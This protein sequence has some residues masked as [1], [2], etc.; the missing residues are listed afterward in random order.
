[1]S[2][3]NMNMD[4]CT[5][6][7]SKRISVANLI[8]NP[9][10]VNNDKKAEGF[11]IFVGSF[12][13]DQVY[14]RPILNTGKN[15]PL[16]IS[17]MWDD[18]GGNNSAAFDVLF[19]CPYLFRNSKDKIAYLTLHCNLTR[20]EVMKI[21][22]K[23]DEFKMYL[24]ANRLIMYIYDGAE[25]GFMSETANSLIIINRK[26]DQPNEWFIENEIIRYNERGH[27]IKHYVTPSDMEYKTVD[28]LGGQKLI[29][30]G[31]TCDPTRFIS[32]SL[33]LKRDDHLHYM[34]NLPVV[35]NRIF[36]NVK[37]ISY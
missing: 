17:K 28:I 21:I 34:R 26:D 10:L 7:K 18:F 30:Y 27:L 8:N 31:V 24:Y 19:A 20:A 22:D 12:H 29:K 25:F 11:R 16:S 1:M 2:M 13:I 36:N 6:S 23:W 15:R 37:Y 4:I 32:E 5:G 35:E 9:V 33:E 14:S 3:K